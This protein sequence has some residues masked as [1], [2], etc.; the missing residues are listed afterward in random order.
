MKMNFT[1]IFV[2]DNANPY[3][4]LMNYDFWPISQRFWSGSNIFGP[5]FGRGNVLYKNLSKRI[6][7]MESVKELQRYYMSRM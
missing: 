6:K 5:K 2:L 4:S 1:T 3:F 7:N